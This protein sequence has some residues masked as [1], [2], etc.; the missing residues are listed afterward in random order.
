MI[1]H[2]QR[3][4]LIH[5]LTDI[6][7]KSN[8]QWIIDNLVA[9]GEWFC[10][11]DDNIHRFTAVCEEEYDVLVMKDKYPEKFERNDQPWRDRVYGQTIDNNRLNKI[12]EQ[13]VDHCEEVGAWY[14]GFSTVDNSFFRGKKYSYCGYVISKAC[15][16][17][18]CGINYDTNVKVMDDYA[19]T[20]ENLIKFG[21][22]VINKYV[23][24][25]A[26]H[27]ENGGIGTYPERLDKKIAHCEYL[28]N[29]YP[30]LFR[31]YEK[32]NCHPKAEIIIRFCRQK[33]V[34]I[35]RAQWKNQ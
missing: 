29:K 33:Q 25:I 22:V 12:L 11:M 4:H 20:A 5:F 18:K 14:G 26:G 10:A 3:S 8:I 7:T 24:P 21:K 1:K 27:Y 15:V 35:W 6:F 2:I 34:D 13:L 32:K 28:M 19:Y 17:K 31:Y 23:F 9:D 16:I 30:N